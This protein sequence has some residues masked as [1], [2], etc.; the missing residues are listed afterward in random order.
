MQPHLLETP[1][2]SPTMIMLRA[3]RAAASCCC[4]DHHFVS[5]RCA[6]DLGGRKF[7]GLANDLQQ[8]V[9]YDSYGYP[10]GAAAGCWARP[11]RARSTPAVSTPPWSTGNLIPTMLKH[12]GQLGR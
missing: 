11:C 2:T 7:E 8:I 3:L 6:I 12:N 9:F 4:S 1:Q 10:A 5:S